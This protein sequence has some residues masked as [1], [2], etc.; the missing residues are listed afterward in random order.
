M[1]KASSTSVTTCTSSEANPLAILCNN[2]TGHT[3]VQTRARQTGSTDMDVL[4]GTSLDFHCTSM[5]FRC[6][7][8]CT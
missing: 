5:N 6:D 4:H 8:P 2:I 3:H 7:F 1:Y